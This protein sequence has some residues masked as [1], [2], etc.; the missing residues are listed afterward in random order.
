MFDDLSV[1][2]AHGVYRLKL[3]FLAG[4]RDTQ[5]S[6]PM[7]SMIGLEGRHDLALRGLPMNYGAK[8]GKGLTNSSV[9][10]AHPGLVRAHVGLRRMVD[11][12]VGE[13]FLE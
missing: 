8:V 12:V 5:K 4:R 2:D 11:E 3:D 1:V 7:R 13:D 6:S 9:E 10:A